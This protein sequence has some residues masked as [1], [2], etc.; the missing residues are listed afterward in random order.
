M[1]L[2]PWATVR[3]MPESPHPI[4]T[5]DNILS[6]ELRGLLRA[7]DPSMTFL[8]DDQLRQSRAG[9]LEGHGGGDLWVFAYGSLIWNPAFHFAECR[10]GRLFGYHRRFCLRTHLG[11]GTRENP[12]LVLGLEA[13]GSCTGLAYRIAEAAIEEETWVL[14]RREMVVGS[15]L[16]RWVSVQGAG[17]AR[18][19]VSFVMNKAHRNYAGRLGQGEVARTLATAEGFLGRSSDYLFEILSGLETHGLQDRRL[20]AI[21]REVR[22]LQA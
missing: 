18:R 8:T 12:G 15:Y 9:I 16:P 20:A 13:G 1:S 5:R 7:R 2:G 10:R 21:A 4:L 11:R 22:R 17:P 14:W 3:R 19:A 6:G